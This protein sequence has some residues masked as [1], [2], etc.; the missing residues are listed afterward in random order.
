MAISTEDRI[1]I[2][3]LI[4][5]H[6]HLMDAGEFDRLDELFSSDVVYDVSDFGFGALHGVAAIRDAA[7]ALGDRNPVGHHVTNVIL[8]E[9]DERTVRVR[10]KGIGIQADGSCGSVGYDDLVRRYPDGW[11]I[12]VRKVTARRAPLGR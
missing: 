10:S 9:I 8:T 6:G 5:L 1:A 12:A 2:N 3:D 11:R 4:A 7:M